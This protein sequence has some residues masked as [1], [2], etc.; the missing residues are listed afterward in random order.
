M[1]AMIFSPLFFP[2]GQTLLSLHLQASI[3]VIE[4]LLNLRAAG[5]LE[6][7]EELGAVSVH[8]LET[9]AMLEA[10]LVFLNQ[11]LD[12]LL[13]LGLP[14]VFVFLLRSQRMR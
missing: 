4:F 1:I 3:K 14:K 12:A 9:V 13:L 7:V 10:D 8:E 2:L 5:G 6:L 11:L